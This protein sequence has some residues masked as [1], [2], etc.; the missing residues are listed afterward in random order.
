MTIAALLVGTIVAHILFVVTKVFFI[1][2]LNMESWGIISAMY[3]V[4]AI[5]TIA[6]SRRMGTLNYFEGIFL[7]L[8]WLGV[9]L[10]TDLVITTSL[11]GRDVYGTIYFWLTYLVISIVVFVFHKKLHVEARKEISGS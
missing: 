9:S 8:V 3:I 10:L 6:V 7:S 5:I 11:T 2:S 4:L 1:N